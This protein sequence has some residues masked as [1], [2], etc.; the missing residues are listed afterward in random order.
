MNMFYSAE[1]ARTVKE[2]TEFD[3]LI[4]HVGKDPSVLY[5]L[6]LEELEKINC[7]YDEIIEQKKAQLHALEGSPFS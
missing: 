3:D 4:T 7:Y 5:T 1:L 6:S 2:I